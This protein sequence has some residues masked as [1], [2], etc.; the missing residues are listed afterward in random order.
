MPIVTFGWNLKALVHV[1]KLSLVAA[2]NIP[3]VPQDCVL[4]I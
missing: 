4:Y 2:E 1:G 3:E